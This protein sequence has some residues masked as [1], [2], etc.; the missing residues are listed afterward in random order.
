M[1]TAMSAGSDSA[2]DIR[3]PCA[4]ALEAVMHVEV[5]LKVM[6]QREVDERT[7]VRRQLHRGGQPSL[8][9]RQITSGKV[10]VEVVHVAA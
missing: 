5:L 10:A 3:P 2:K 6:G 7:L 4:V 9:H 8:N 1:A